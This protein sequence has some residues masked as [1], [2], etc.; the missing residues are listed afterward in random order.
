M[1]MSIYQLVFVC[2]FISFSSFSKYTPPLVLLSIDGFSNN[3]LTKYK[4]KNILALAQQGVIANALLPVFPSKT[5]PNHLSIITGVYPA[6][7]GIIH[8][9]FYNRSLNK[10]YSLGA[11][12]FDSDWINSKPI[13]T[14]AEQNNIKT[15]I[16]FWPESEAIIDNT[17]VSYLMPYND[18]TPNEKR[19]DTIIDWLKIS[20]VDRP[21]LILG[22]FSTID[23]AGHRYGPNSSQ[24]KNAIYNLDQLI[25]KFIEKLEKEINEPINLIIVSDHG[26]VP[27][28]KDKTI[29]WQYYLNENEQVKV[30]NSET[31]LL[32]YADSDKNLVGIRE[33]LAEMAKSKG[34]LNYNVFESG[35]YPSHWHFNTPSPAI[36]NIILNAIAPYTFSSN[37]RHFNAA[38]H[39]FDPKN[40]R[41]LDAIFIANGPSFKEGITIGEFENIHIFPLLLSMLNIAIPQEINGDLTVLNPI[42]NKNNVLI[43]EE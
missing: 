6:Q 13:W 43:I 7:H 4:P 27:I 17:K 35:N 11:G 41:D 16:Y 25:G 2:L 23:N 39:G 14:I 42:L 8:N 26:M 29:D 22:Y 32:I 40:M 36:P 18:D 5:F 31:Q 9:K 38:T 20:D 33:Q 24:V 28:D 21:K 3:Y 19:F 1:Q 37:K 15:A 30:V 10:L 34:S 12:K